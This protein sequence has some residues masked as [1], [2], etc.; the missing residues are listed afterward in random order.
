MDAAREKVMEQVRRHFKPELLNRLDEIVVFD[1]L[2]HEQLRRVARLQMK[3]VAKRLAERG[4]ALGVTD[5]ALDYVLAESYDPVYGAR[6]IRK[7]LEKKVVTE[8]SKMLIREEIDENST[9][10]IEAGSRDL[11]IVWKKMAGW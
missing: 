1:P 6:P 4:I 2:S 11:F 3:D 7:W 5:A 9:V 10:Y 8:M